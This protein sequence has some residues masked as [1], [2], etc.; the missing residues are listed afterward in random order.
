MNEPLLRDDIEYVIHCD[1]KGKIIG[2]LSKLHAHLPGPRQVL[3][4]YSTWAMVF[5]PKSGRYGIQLKNPKKHDPFGAGKWDMG[6]AGHNC[7]VKTR[8]RENYRSMGFAETLTKEG[9]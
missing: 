1:E 5:H 3:T 8:E 2:P 4:H 6:I 7:Y 9:D